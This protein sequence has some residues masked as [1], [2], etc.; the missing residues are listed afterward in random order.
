M[1]NIAP[2]FGTC[3]SLGRHVGWPHLKQDDVALTDEGTTLF[4]TLTTGK[5]GT[6]LIFTREDKAQGLV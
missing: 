5:P 6:S 4:Q 3:P 1:P 2:T